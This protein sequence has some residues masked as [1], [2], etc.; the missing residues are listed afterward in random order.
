MQYANGWVFDSYLH[1]TSQSMTSIT[2]M[3]VLLGCRVGEHIKIKDSKSVSISA[4]YPS[5]LLLCVTGIPIMLPNCPVDNS[6]DHES[7]GAYPVHSNMFKVNVNN[8]FIPV[9]GIE[10]FDVA[11]ENNVESWYQL[12]HDGW[13]SSAKTGAKW[14]ISFSGKRIIGDPGNDFLASSIMKNIITDIQWIFPDGS[15]LSQRM[16]VTAEEYGGDTV[17]VNAI[18][19]KMTSTG[20]PVFLPAKRGD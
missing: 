3:P 13:E 14:N 20:K 1:Q 12:E 17:G 5:G 7:T 18:K 6:A 16:I 19:V 2:E 9:K 8:R 15:S 4:P 10:T 11:F